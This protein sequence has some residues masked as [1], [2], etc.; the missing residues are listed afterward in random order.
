VQIEER[1]GNLL[2][3]EVSRRI[4]SNPRD[5]EDEDYIDVPASPLPIGLDIRARGGGFG[6]FG[7]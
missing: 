3:E 5:E 4:H 7:F 6:G 2:L 1:R